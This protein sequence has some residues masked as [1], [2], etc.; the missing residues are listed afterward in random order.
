MPEERLRRKNGFQPPLHQQQLLSWFGYIL[1][2]VIYFTIIF[3]TLTKTA[4]IAVTIAYMAVWVVY[5][6]MFIQ[7][8]L[9]EHED[10]SLPASSKEDKFY[11]SWC[12]GYVKNGCKH[13]GCCNR[14]RPEFDHHCFFLNNCVTNANYWQFFF[15]ILF[16]AISSLFT[17]FLCIWV[18]MAMEYDNGETLMRVNEFYGANV[19]KAVLIVFCAIDMIIMLGIQ[20]FMMYLFALH[21]LLGRR[22]ITTFQLITWRRQQNVMKDA[23]A[24]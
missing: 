17:T 20:V 8:S 14:C 21:A 24:T 2:V 12:R 1:E 11:C 15:G 19:H 18:I 4:R 9:E 13:C 16:L 23:R 5:N 22:K 10:P 7:A 3:P 6:T